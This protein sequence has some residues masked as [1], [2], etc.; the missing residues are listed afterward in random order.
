MHK[1]ILS[2]L[3]SIKLKSSLIF[4]KNQDYS[5]IYF[6]LKQNISN[7][8]HNNYFEPSNKEEEIE[9]VKYWLN[10]E[11][12]KYL[13]IFFTNDWNPICKEANKNYVNFAR[14]TGGF[15]NLRIDTEKFPRL[16][17][18]FDC[19]NAPGFHFY[20]YGAQIS[21]L[22]GSNYDRALEETKRIQSNIDE[23]F[24]LMEFKPNNVTYEQPY[25]LFEQ[26]YWNHGLQRGIDPYQLYKTSPM[27]QAG[28]FKW[29][30][31]EDRYVHRRLKR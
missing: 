1:Q 31:F 17:W 25:F 28:I 18:Y 24:E 15:R 19:K 29:F 22:G 11:K 14:K 21:K 12:P 23:S 2:K 13:C 10:K 6:L 7:N 27:A 3:N 26:D 5:K 16:K 20:Y 8:F 4:K 30:C 9:D